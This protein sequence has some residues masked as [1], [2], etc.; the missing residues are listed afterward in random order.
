MPD[1]PPLRHLSVAPLRVPFI[2]E[3]KSSGF[4][5]IFDKHKSMSMTKHYRMLYIFIAILFVFHSDFASAQDCYESTIMSP[6]PFMV[7][8]DEIFKLS[9]GSIWKVKYEYEYL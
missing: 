8:D 2:P 6:T 9:D 3:L 1:M 5:G 4:S 7:N